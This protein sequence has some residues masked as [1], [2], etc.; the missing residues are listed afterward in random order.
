MPKLFSIHKGTV[1]RVELPCLRA[2]GNVLTSERGN[3]KE[4]YRFGGPLKSD[5]STGQVQDYGAFV[6]LG[7]G[8]RYKDSRVCLGRF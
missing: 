6:R 4:P 8:S 7:D 2:L 1:A 5:T 3:Q